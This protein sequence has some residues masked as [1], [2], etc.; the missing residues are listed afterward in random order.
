MVCRSDGCCDRAHASMAEF[1]SRVVGRSLDLDRNCISWGE[2]VS[3]SVSDVDVD[4][5][6][7]F[8]SSLIS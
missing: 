7:V 5:W 2:A 3:V 8:N 4:A 6:L 1:M